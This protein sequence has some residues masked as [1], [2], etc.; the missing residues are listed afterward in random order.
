MI[1]LFCFMYKMNWS[2]QYSR[3]NY[4]VAYHNVSLA[5][6]LRIGLDV[7]TIS[8]TNSSNFKKLKFVKILNKPKIAHILVKSLPN[9]QL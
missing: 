1:P 8:V 3:F 6:G 9:T 7:G 5:N 4:L 2:N